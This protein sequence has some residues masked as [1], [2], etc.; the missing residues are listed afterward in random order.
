MKNLR[1]LIVDDVEADIEYA[2]AILR[3]QGH[4]ILT[5]N[6]GEQGVTMAAQEMPDLILM[7]VVMPEVNGFQ[8]T[9]Q[10]TKNAATRDIPV[11]VVSC[12]DQETDKLWAMKQGARAYLTKQLNKAALFDTIET[13]MA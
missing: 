7:D 5:A 6:N 13:V 2:A 10:L 1:I 4:T 12:K 8:A 11:I 3:Q 9:R